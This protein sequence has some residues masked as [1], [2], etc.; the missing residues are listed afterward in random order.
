[1]EFYL[2]CRIYLHGVHRDKF[3]TL[4]KRKVG[5]REH[6][7]CV[8]VCVCVCACVRACACVRPSFEFLDQVTNS[9]KVSI[10]V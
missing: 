9:V 2:R 5:F 6:S 4:N 10:A 1:M 3:L 7:V 8:C